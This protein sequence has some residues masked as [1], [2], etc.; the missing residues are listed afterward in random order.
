MELILNTGKKI[1]FTPENLF[2][3]ND[4]LYM[5]LEDDIIKFNESC[6]INHW[7]NALEKKIILKSQAVK[8]RL[9]IC[10]YLQIQYLPVYTLCSY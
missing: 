1:L 5:K 8:P 10:V 4:M 2:I 6:L 3:K 7:G 9:Q